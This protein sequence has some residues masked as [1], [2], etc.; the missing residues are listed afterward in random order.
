MILEVKNDTETLSYKYANKPFF[1]QLKRVY[2]VIKKIPKPENSK[3]IGFYLQLMKKV[4]GDFGKIS[5]K[6]IRD[7]LGNSQSISPNDF[8]KKIINYEVPPGEKSYI[9]PETAF[10][11]TQRF[12]SDEKLNKTISIS[13]FGNILKNILAKYQ[14]DEK[15]DNALQII[16]RKMSSHFNNTA[17]FI[18][19][20]LM[21]KDWM[22]IDAFQSDFFSSLKATKYKASK[23]TSEKEE[24]KLL[25][26]VTND[27]LKHEIEFYKTGISFLVLKNPGIKVLTV[28]TPEIIRKVENVRNSSK[29]RDL[30]AILP[31]KLGFKLISISKLFNIL[32]TRSNVEKEKAINRFITALKGKPGIKDA[33]AKKEL[34]E[35]AKYLEKNKEKLKTIQD[36]DKMINK[37]NI[38][39]SVKDGIHQ[40]IP[41]IIEAVQKKESIIEIFNKNMNK[42]MTVIRQS[43]EQIDGN[44]WWSNRGLVFEDIMEDIVKK[45]EA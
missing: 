33:I 5:E 45:A 25:I 2:R 18:R 20:T 24:N 26:Q 19:Y 14:K 8:I 35:T 40:L 30:Y 23:E 3:K 31:K 12:I 39:Q 7:V 34:N 37:I 11:T 4:P 44:I 36:I 42:V 32:R 9:S 29:I 17:S 1:I 43:S 22:H 41:K 27:F 6:I 38:N 28:N 13:P 16:S 15:F 21:S 10:Q